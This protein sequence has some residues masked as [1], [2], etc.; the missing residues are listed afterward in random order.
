MFILQYTK[1]INISIWCL[2]THLFHRR[3]HP[4]NEFPFNLFSPHLQ[5]Q[6]SIGEKFSINFS[7]ISFYDF[8]ELK[9]IWPWHGSSVWKLQFSCRSFVMQKNTLNG[10]SNLNVHLKHFQSQ[11]NKFREF[12]ILLGKLL[13]ETLQ[14]FN[15]I[16]FLS[17][18]HPSESL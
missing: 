18:I 7:S 8:K 1:F 12:F 6:I 14:R 10:F 2:F 17:Q 9:S 15:P 11:I 13:L 4:L 16:Y 3:F 5:T